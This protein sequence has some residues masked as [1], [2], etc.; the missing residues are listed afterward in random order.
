MNNAADVM[1]DRLRS[2]YSELM[3]GRPPMR[4]EDGGGGG[5]GPGPMQGIER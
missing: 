2:G 3:N 1:R 5:Y 4:P